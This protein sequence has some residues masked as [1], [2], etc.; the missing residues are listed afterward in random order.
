MCV[1]NH[2]IYRKT[3]GV[4][5]SITLIC[6]IMEVNANYFVLQHSIERI[7]PKVDGHSSW[8]I[9]IVQFPCIRW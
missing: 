3:C 1:D 4:R 9:G 6:T 2:S 8:E 7:P 5:T